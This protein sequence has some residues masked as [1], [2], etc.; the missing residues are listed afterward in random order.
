MKKLIA[1]LIFLPIISF[2]FEYV[3]NY[4]NE[5][6]E[7]VNYNLKF[8]KYM[9]GYDH[10]VFVKKQTM[11]KE[12]PSSSSKSLKKLTVNKNY[13]VISLVENEK[14]EKWYEILLEDDSLA[15]VKRDFVI[16]REF[17]FTSALEHANRVNE[18]IDKYK[19]DIKVVNKY[20]PLNTDSKR[21]NDKYGNS[22][23]QAILA[24]TSENK[25]E[26]INL[27]D[28]SLVKVINQGSKF[29]EVESPAYEGSLFI[30]NSYKLNLIDSGLNDVVNKF[31]YISKKSQNQITFEKNSENLGY[32]ILSVGYVT[33]GK[34]GKYG[35][36]TPY[37][38]FLVA[39][40]KPVMAYASDTDSTKII[41]DAKYAVRFTGGGYMHGIPSTYE[42]VENREA[43]KK[44]TAAR[45]G[46]YPLSHKCVRN[47]DD[48]IK[49][50]YDWI[51]SKGVTKSGL[52]L[53]KEPA[54]VIVR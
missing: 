52:R 54:I 26:Y 30:P 48:S 8:D 18:F 36:E 10:Y 21:K 33:T 17:D 9:P 25:K 35:F 28:R 7:N 24:Y 53:P 23:N 11:A 6:I 37:G 16:K 41:G 39:G 12:L 47:E 15:Y 45:L 50:I 34:D 5:R 38:D 32:N 43:R 31:I 40:T 22:D 51:G 13:P 3:E 1:F 46:T 2:S 20:D 4:S 42:P 19:G 44:S 49:Y 27:P 29:L 14:N